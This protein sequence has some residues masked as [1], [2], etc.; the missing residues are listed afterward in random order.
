[1]GI[2]SEGFFG[3]MQ[4]LTCI[5]DVENKMIEIILFIDSLN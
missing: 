2:D 1:M 5:Q 4:K 3:Q